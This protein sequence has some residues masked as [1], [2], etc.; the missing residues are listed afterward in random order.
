MEGLS[1]RLS[2][3]AV[4]V[5]VGP[6]VD[7]EKDFRRNVRA[8]LRNAKAEDV[9]DLVVDVVERTIVNRVDDSTRNFDGETFANAVGAAAPTGINEPNF[10][11][12]FGHIGG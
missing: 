1:K 2:G 10:R 8:G 4:S 3:L 6:A 9:V 7:R 12:V 5:F 11:T